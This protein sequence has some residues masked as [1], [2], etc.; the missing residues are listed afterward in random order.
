MKVK[1]QKKKKAKRP[2]EC[3]YRKQLESNHPYKYTKPYL[4]EHNQACA[5]LHAIELNQRKRLNKRCLG[6]PIILD[7]FFFSYK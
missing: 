2:V 1:L 3:P 4:F 7:Y 6:K 5:L